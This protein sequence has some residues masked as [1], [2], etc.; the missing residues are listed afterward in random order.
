M[1]TYAPKKLLNLW[2]KDEMDF[3]K[4]TGHSLQNIVDL[5]TKQTKTQ[6]KTNGLEHT[7]QNMAKDQEKLQ[8]KMKDLQAIVLKQ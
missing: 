1:G 2:I 7:V 4:V 8:L 3:E 6:A 5:A